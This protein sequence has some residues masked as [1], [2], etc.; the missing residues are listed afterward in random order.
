M[1]KKAIITTAGVALLGAFFFGR[2]VVSY[3][4]TSAHM[5]RDSVT[6]QIPPEFQIE[7]AR[8]ELKNLVPDIVRNVE[9]IA[10][11]QV[12]VEELDNQIAGAEKRLG[13]EKVAIKRLAV[14][15]KSGN[16]IFHYA[17]RSFTRDQVKTDLSNRF[18]RY[19][20]HEGTLGSL[21]DMRDARQRTLEGARQNL[22]NMV[23]MK[24]RLEV[25]LE[26]VEAKLKMLEAQQTAS[27]YAF[28]NSRLSRAKKLIDYL[29]KR[30]AVAA[31][32]MDAKGE[33]A[34]EIPLT[35]GPIDDDIIDEVTEYFAE[36]EVGETTQVA[37][38]PSE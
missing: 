24:Q 5:V 13:Q 14:D 11:E 10:H 18:E 19:R 22:E 9:T 17:S 37:V 1:I 28:D 27:R 3:V 16:G 21:R 29:D 30:L 34:V 26:N 6:E 35:E 4:S 33:W 38:L 12:E 32:V 7:R 25:K 2:D 31:K 23:A 36:D 15:L 20:T 8:R